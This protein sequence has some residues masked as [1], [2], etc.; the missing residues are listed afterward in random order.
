MRTIFF[1]L[2]NGKYIADGDGS[3]I[4]TEM[5]MENDHLINGNYGSVTIKDKIKYCSNC[6]KSSCCGYCD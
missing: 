5:L 2:E 1:T 3:E 4:T 6:G